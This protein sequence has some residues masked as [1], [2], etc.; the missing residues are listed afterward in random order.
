MTAGVVAPGVPGVPWAAGGSSTRRRYTSRTV[1]VSSGL[2]FVEPDTKATRLPS[3]CSDGWEDEASPLAPVAPAARLASATAPVSRS[4]TY[5]SAAAS[6]SAGSRF[7]PC[8]MNATRRPSVEIDASIEG[9]LLRAPA[10]PG[11]RLTSVVVAAARSRRNT[12]TP[13]SVSAGSSVVAPESKATRRPSREIRARW[14]PR[15]PAAPVAP[16]ARLTSVVVCAPTSR[17]TTSTWPLTSPGTRSVAFVWNATREPSPE[18][19]GSAESPVPLTP[20]PVARLTRVVVPVERSRRK[21]SEMVSRSSGSRFVAVERNA[22]YRP[23]AETDG[24]ADSRFAFV[25]PAPRLTS[26]VVRATV[27][28]R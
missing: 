19:V 23:S 5:T 17:T 11:A 1:S 15:S 28:R 13:S 21:T 3:P 14:D 7:V 16:V 12:S 24:S 10:A 26:V 20:A 25:P 22:T 9:P 6:R 18:I 4:R 8:E 2:R 27:S